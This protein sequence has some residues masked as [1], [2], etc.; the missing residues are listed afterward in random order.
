MKDLHD[1]VVGLDSGKPGRPQSVCL[2][3]PSRG[4]RVPRRPGFTLTVVTALPSLRCVNLV[5]SLTTS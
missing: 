4:T 1:C 2:Y 3:S 5:S